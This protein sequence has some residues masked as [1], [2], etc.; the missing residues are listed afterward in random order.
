MRRAYPDL[1]EA[2]FQERLLSLKN[3]QALEVPPLPRVT[4]AHEFTELSK[5]FCSHYEKF[6]YQYIIQ[7][8]LSNTSPYRGILVYHGLGFGKTCSAITFAEEW[9]NQFTGV[10]NDEIWVI[11]SVALE[12]NFKSQLFQRKKMKNKEDREK[13]CASGTYY[14]LMMATPQIE[15]GKRIS[16]TKRMETIQKAMD[17]RYRFFSYD[18]FGTFVKEQGDKLASVAQNRVIIV[19]EAHNLRNPDVK[20]SSGLEIF[21]E[22][23]TNNRLVL[24]SATPMFD[25]PDEILRMLYYLCLNDKRTDVPSLKN[26]TFYKNG[27]TNKALLKHF[28]HLC[29]N[30]ISYVKGRNPFS[31]ATRLSPAQSGLPLLLENEVASRS[32]FGKE[33]KDED[34]T[35]IHQVDGGLFVSKMTSNQR[36]GFDEPELMRTKTK[37]KALHSERIVDESE[38]IARIPINTNILEATNIVF[39]IKTSKGGLKFKFGYQGL[40]SIVKENRDKKLYGFEYYNEPYLCPGSEYLGSIACKMQTI[41]EKAHNANGIVL[42]FSH[43]IWSG[44]IPLAMA[45]EHLGYTRLS[46]QNFLKNAEQYKSHVKSPLSWSTGHKYV[47]L[48]SDTKISGVDSFAEVLDAVNHDN[49]KDGEKVKIVLMSPVASEGISFLNVREVHILD[50][51][52]HFNRL[53]QVIGRSIRTCSHQ[54]LPVEKRNVT[55]FLHVAKHM[56][57]GDKDRETYDQHVYHLAADKKIRS[58]DIES[59]IRNNALDCSLQKHV[60]FYPKRL[61]PF[62]LE[63]LTSQHVA[64]MHSYGD[65]ESIEPRCTVSLPSARANDPVW[66]KEKFL[67]LVKIAHQRLNVT[68]S[69]GVR[70][71]NVRQWDLSA[72]IES[73]GLP[74]DVAIVAIKEYANESLRLV[75]SGLRYRVRMNRMKLWIEPIQPSLTNVR[76]SIQSFSRE[77]PEKPSN[78]PDADCTVANA[79]ILAYEFDANI[80][81]VTI[82]RFL[83]FL[84]PLCWPSLAKTIVKDQ[85]N[86]N[87]TKSLWKEGWLV[88]KSELSGSSTEWLGY[89]DV[90]IVTKNKDQL[91]LRILDTHGES[92]NGNGNGQWRDGTK[93]ET[94]TL[95]KRRV[96]KS[97]S[98]GTNTDMYGFYVVKESKKDPISIVL[99][100]MMEAD[101]KRAK[102]GIVGA[103]IPSKELQST[104]TKLEN[105]YMEIKNE[106]FPIKPNFDD[107]KTGKENRS[108]RTYLSSW[109]AY[110]LGFLDKLFIP[111]FYKPR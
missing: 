55:V 77:H 74:R 40:S 91:E 71:Q 101:G 67:P 57:E 7:Q 53:E 105:R 30:Y 54:A 108:N 47:L 78:D 9:L 11:T 16:S 2:D 70:E 100:L 63:L 28:E 48:C 43:Y 20:G 3:Y 38:Q 22:A 15:N 14:D 62:Q 93:L 45:F 46:G 17:S 44:I 39:P 49:N 60:N 10:T 69:K 81:P 95:K 88:R 103:T 56:A 107:T 27:V 82:V 35:W 5:K 97:P 26:A 34:R 31:L 12:E 76:V 61:F 102:T 72:L 66:R 83:T 23:G 8:H 51:W 41:I 18:K 13:Q 33:I 96:V 32:F 98:T 104:L 106:P 68:L 111:P 87:L 36:L 110:Y 75:I 65:D 86:N 85:I 21:L 4:S 24:L 73:L 92:G 58:N 89:I 50:P 79:D 94:D 25:Q 84:N 99:K 42:I 1:S 6:L 59:R 64:T 37:N 19:D 80:H 90:F 29:S 52:Y 109:V